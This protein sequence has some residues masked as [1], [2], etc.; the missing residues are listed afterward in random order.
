MGNIQKGLVGHWQMDGSDFDSN[1]VR[2]RSA[3]DNHLSPN[4]GSPKF[5]DFGGVVGNGKAKFD[6]SNN[7]S[8]YNSSFKN[9]SD[10]IFSVSMWIKRKGNINSEGFWGF[11]GGGTADGIN[12]Y[13]RGSNSSCP[14]NA[15][16]W[17]L[18]GS[19]RFYTSKTYPLDN[20]IHVVWIKHSSG[21]Q[22]SSLINYVNN[23]KFYPTKACS[24]GTT[25]PT[26]VDGFTL[27]KIGPNHRTPSVELD[28][29]RVYDR[30]LREDEIN[31]LYNR[32]ST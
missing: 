26:V 12:N 3:Y 5:Q 25:S 30:V 27:G 10:P 28:D 7:E 4:N 2:D 22:E 21:M 19:Q 29:V 23:E 11:G 18:W 16:G 32:R 14:A 1:T 20:W 13:I 6:G 31:I 24:S 8:I 17:D 15:I 9:D